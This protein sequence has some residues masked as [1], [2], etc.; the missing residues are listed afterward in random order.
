MTVVYMH[1]VLAIL[2]AMHEFVVVESAPGK[3][4]DMHPGCLGNGIR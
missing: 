3:V 2:P 4:Q 1:D